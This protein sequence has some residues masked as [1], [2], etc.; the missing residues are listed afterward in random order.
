VVEMLVVLMATL[1]PEVIGLM[2]ITRNI[3]NYS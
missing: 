1:S 2:T 3:V